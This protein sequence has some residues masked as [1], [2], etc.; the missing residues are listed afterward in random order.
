[1]AY[2][3][4]EASRERRMIVRDTQR[5]TGEE[6]VSWARSCAIDETG[7]FTS[8]VPPSDLAKMKKSFPKGVGSHSSDT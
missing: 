5:R 6:D 8:S 4:V 3:E 7:D 1:M 2:G